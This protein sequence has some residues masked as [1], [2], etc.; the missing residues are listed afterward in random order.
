MDKLDM[1]PSQI[2]LYNKRKTQAWIFLLI[3]PWFNI[4]L[5]SSVLFVLDAFT[6]QLFAQATFK[7]WSGFGA[8][9]LLF[10]ALEPVLARL[11]PP[12]LRHNIWMLRPFV[13]I[14][15]YALIGPIVNLPINPAAPQVTF[16]PIVIMLLETLVY[17]AVM[18]MF[19]QQT[20]HFQSQLQTQKAELQILKMQSNPHFLFNT[21]NLIAS[22]VTH[23]PQN[24]KG[25]IYD[26]SDLL[27]Q[28]IQQ[29]KKQFIPLEQELK[30]VEL[31]LVLQQK[32]FAD[33]FTFD[34]DCHSALEQLP[35]PS[36][37]LLPIVENA[38]KYG[39]APY[40]KAGHISIIIEEQDTD[41]LIEV[42][43][44]GVQFDDKQ[45]VQGEGLRITTE[46]LK[47]H[48]LSNA[49]LLLKS[50]DEGTSAYIKLPA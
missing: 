34:I 23:N 5:L 19:K 29:A 33:R 3:W 43:D 16:L 11:F 2:G 25:L 14:I 7:V 28:T 37:L 38:V 1:P 21:L 13:I 24:A 39:I 27:R 42:Q 46:T 45:V 15:L 41:L 10:N 12:H 35:V 31:Y 48:Y 30:L 18:L 47:L 22:E 40:A 6:L 50:S 9:Y 17:I 36:L 4:L 49:S 44:T 32:R 20:Y 26:L 8:G